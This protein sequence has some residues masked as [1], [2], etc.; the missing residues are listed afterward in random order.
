MLLVTP[1]WA[2]AAEVRNDPSA[3]VA[4]EET[5]DEDVFVS[6][7]QM[8]TISGHVMG[9]A[10]AVANTVI[11]NGT[12][13]GDL[14]AAAQQVI[15]EGTIRGNLRAAGSSVTINGDVGRNVTGLAQHV[16]LSSNARVDG[17]ILVAAQS[18]N[19]LG[20]VGR[21][22]TVG[23]GALQLAG[24]VGGP[25]QARVESLSVAPSAHLASTLDY[26]AR[27]PAAVPEGTVTGAVH[28]TATPQPA[29]RPTPQPAAPLL[30]GLFDLGGLVGLAGSFLIGALALILMPRASARAVELGRQRPWQSFGLGA[31]VL[32]ATPIAALLVAITL[33]G[34][35]VAFLITVLYMLGL[36]LATP[37][38]G[39]V[40]GMELMRLIRPDRPLAVLGTL[41]VGLIVVHLVTHLPFIG[42]LV[43][44]CAIAYGLGMVAQALRHSR[45]HREP[46][47]SLQTFA[48]A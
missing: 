21:G 8:A 11:V 42:P 31:L 38:V 28:F 41:A 46:T 20:Q 15:V 24:P 32:V 34:L 48:A 18:I 33:I 37:A 25:V 29:P 17:S 47:A 27:Q 22:I 9:D 39:L 23:G 5:I 14:I 3:R 35:P 40:A 4:P 26:Q 2:M 10:Y 43:G 45:Q 6:S 16:T 12:I 19:A 1:A 7:A 13:D 30:D 44:M 36:F